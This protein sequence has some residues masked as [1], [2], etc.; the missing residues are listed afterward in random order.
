MPEITLT[1]Y[2]GLNGTN[3]SAFR[4]DEDGVSVFE[5][6]LSGYKYNLP[7]RAFY[8]SEKAAGT[9]AE[10]IEPMLKEGIAEYTPQFGEGHWSLRFPDLEAQ[11]IK[12]LLSKYAKLMLK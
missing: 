2:R 10:I 5:N 8:Q 6:P 3:P 1:L 7:I 9:V 12:I 11:D 4:I